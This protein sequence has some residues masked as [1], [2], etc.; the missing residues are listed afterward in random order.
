MNSITRLEEHQLR[1]RLENPVLRALPTFL[2]SYLDEIH[3]GEIET[4]TPIQIAYASADC[5]AFLVQNAE[6]IGLMLPQAGR[7]FGA[8]RR[9]KLANAFSRWPEDARMR[10][11]VAAIDFVDP[12]YTGGT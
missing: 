9:R 6:D 1:T 3:D 4:L 11:M 5:T 10:L 2:A 12:T 7:D 8:V